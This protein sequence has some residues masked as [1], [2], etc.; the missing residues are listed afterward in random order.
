MTYSGEVGGA[1]GLRDELFAALESKVS[2]AIR[3][4][5]ASSL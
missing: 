1:P 4:P 5:I 3:G 2:L